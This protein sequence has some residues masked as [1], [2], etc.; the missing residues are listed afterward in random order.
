MEDRVQDRHDEFHRGVVVVQE[1]HLVHWGLLELLLPLGPRFEI[2]SL[3]YGHP[4]APLSRMRK[5]NIHHEGLEVEGWPENRPR[6]PSPRREGILRQAAGGTEG[7]G[8]GLASP[9]GF[10]LAWP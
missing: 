3:F 1:D 9:L 4:K 6:T 5:T 7:E 8:S 2:D 10:H